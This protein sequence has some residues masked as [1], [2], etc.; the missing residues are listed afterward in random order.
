[1][2]GILS[3]PFDIDELIEVVAQ[4]ARQAVPFADSPAADAARTAA[5]AARLEAAG[6]RDIHTSERR[7]WAVCRT[8]DDALVQLYWWQREGV[9]YVLR[10]P[11][12]M[13]Q[14][15]GRFYDQELAI[16]LALKVQQTG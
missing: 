7:E 2:A 12:G 5:L 16:R 13:P 8:P 11:D 3:K 15:V 6:A 4:A 10:Y 14:L 9:Y 1:V